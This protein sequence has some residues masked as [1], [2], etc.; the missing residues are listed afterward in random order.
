MASILF[1]EPGDK[2]RKKA[3]PSFLLYKKWLIISVIINVILFSL[4]LYKL[5][6]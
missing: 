3:K 6:T 1:R 4:L 5:T 2:R